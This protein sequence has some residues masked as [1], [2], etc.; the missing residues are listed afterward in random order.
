MGLDMYLEADFSL[1]DGYKDSKLDAIRT[2]VKQ[3]FNG[4][5][6]QENSFIGGKVTV[7]LAY[8]RK[9]NQIHRWFV[10]T[11]QD[12]IDECQRAYVS[13]EQ[14]MR[15]RTKCRAALDNR[16]NAEK[17]L[18]TQP[19]FFFGGTEY[20]DWYFKQLEYTIG[21]LD[22]ILEKL[23]KSAEIYYHSSW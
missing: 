22:R 4:L 12:N 8:W 18:P 13:K 3:S 10:Q 7:P 9:A 20:D 5:I 21:A 17:L 1:Y 15:L 16:K 19:G 6:E 2:A 11:V 23:P 14:L